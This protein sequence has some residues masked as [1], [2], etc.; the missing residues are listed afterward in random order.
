MPRLPKK[1]FFDPKLS[2]EE[3]EF[4]RLAKT[5]HIA[6]PVARLVAGNIEGHSTSYG[7]G[8]TPPNML[9]CR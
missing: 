8:K 5:D 7:P 4:S 1:G 3:M 6:G 9:W 2:V